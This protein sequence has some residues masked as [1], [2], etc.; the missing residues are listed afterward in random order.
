MKTNIDC[1]VKLCVQGEI[2]HPVTANP[3]YTSKDG[4]VSTLPAMGGITYNVKVGDPAFGWAADH[5]EPCVTMKNDEEVA[6]NAL[7]LLACIGNEAI[8]AS[9]D[10]KGTKGY[11]TGTHGG[12]EHII[13]NFEEN[14][15]RMAIGDKIIVKAYGQG[16]RLE[17]FPS[18]KVLNIDP[19]LFSLLNITEESGKLI[20]PVAGIV[21]AHLM[22]SGIGAASSNRGDYDITTT[23]MEEI[24]RNGLD[25][26]RLGDVV[27]LRDCDNSYGRAY[28]KGAVSI[29]V[30]I[31]GDSV[32]MGHGPGVTT[33]MTCKESLI[34]GV[35]TGSANIADYLK[36]IYGGMT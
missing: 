19:G 27:M 32:R 10:A 6:N 26:L 35:V 24:R 14:L 9:G 30:V 20:M 5:V 15:D 25:R 11:I 21:P 29:G 28:L 12:V 1:L 17:D 33:I 8:V 3:Y 13:I 2:K 22:G 4:T 18:V 7:N 31:H 23:D 36:G 16:F 34:D